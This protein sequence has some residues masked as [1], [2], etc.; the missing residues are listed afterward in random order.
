[1]QSQ[2]V[3][4]HAEDTFARLCSAE[5]ITCNSPKHDEKGWD[6]FLEFPRREIAGV[7]LDMAP[8]TEKCLVQIK[9]CIG[10]LKPIRMK[11]S[12]AFEL[13]QT[14]LPAFVVQFV[15]GKQSKEVLAIYAV[16]F[17][18][19]AISRTLQRVRKLEKMN[20]T[21]LQRSYVTLPV[22]QT[23]MVPPP[24][25][26]AFI[27]R[28]LHK[29]GSNY[30][31]SKRRLRETVGFDSVYASG[32]IKFKPGVRIEEIIDM[33][34]GL[35]ESVGVTAFTAESLRFGIPLKWIDLCDGTVQ[36]RSHPVS[37]SLRVS[38]TRTGKEVE[39]PS[40][41]YF[42]SIPGLPIDQQKARLTNHFIDIVFTLGD[43]N[44]KYSSNWNWERSYTLDE[45]ATMYKLLEIYSSGHIH[46]QIN[47]KDKP[48]LC[49][50]G[51]SEPFEISRVQQIL[52]R[53][54]ELLS[55]N[56]PP[57][58]IP[59][60]F[61]VNPA[62]LLPLAREI[63]EFVELSTAQ[64]INGSLKF[65]WRGTGYTGPG[66]MIAYAAVALKNAVAYAITRRTMTVESGENGEGHAKTG[67]VQSTV[68]RIL[69]GSLINTQA[70]VEREVEALS[71][72]I[73]DMLVLTMH[74]PLRSGTMHSELPSQPADRLG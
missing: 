49:A 51:P 73:P 44:I 8:P 47:A 19:E 48:A 45:L 33:T 52:G 29:I 2:N 14:D 20:C 72:G 37:C 3:P 28:Q 21:Q 46:F 30:A 70:I 67:A 54:I 24:D 23:T 10:P 69:Q 9:S 6:F 71:R 38:S 42:S 27:E 7:P 18:E 50:D 66:L 63:N 55:A 4:R 31:E 40:K 12:N 62:D 64:E 60:G 43:L 35:R 17:W 11:L 22:S 25:V 39:V 56:V 5:G 41:M 74:G 58:Q 68:Y 65:K 59:T 36:M 1:M 26:V 16:H 15:Y 61:V 13:A 53:F 32:Q 57:H 34:I